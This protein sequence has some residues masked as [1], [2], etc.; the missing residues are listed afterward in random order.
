MLISD[1]IIK[2]RIFDSIFS[3]DEYIAS[4]TMALIKFKNL[5]EL[6]MKELNTHCVLVDRFE[7][8]VQQSIYCDLR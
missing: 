8:P 7:L 3:V 1:L 4:G 2:P 6:R 5:V